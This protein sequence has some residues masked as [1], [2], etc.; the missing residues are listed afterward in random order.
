MY[1]EEMI[2]IENGLTTPQKR[3]LIE[4]TTTMVNAINEDELIAICK[5]YES[6]CN[7]LLKNQNTKI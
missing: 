2:K 7:R 3:Q 6:A 5:I 4:M 1:N